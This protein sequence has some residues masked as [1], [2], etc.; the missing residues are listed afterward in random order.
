MR[1]SKDLVGKPV[2]TADEGRFLGNVK[3]VY[4]DSDLDWLAGIHL[5][6]EGL[7]RRKSLLVEREAV[8]VFGIDAILVK[9]AAALSDD[10][11]SKEAED[12]IRLD[13][14]RGRHVDTPGGTKVGVIGDVAL[15]AEARIVGVTLSKVLVAGPIAEKRFVPRAAM[16]DTGD[17]DGAMTIDLTKA[18]QPGHVA[19][20]KPIDEGDE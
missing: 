4:L 18:E 2:Y 1:H 16:L 13:E 12:W 7:I 3:D 10:R 15:D 9:N 8:I 11:E 19:G 17:E 5:G 14:L 6:T 20:I